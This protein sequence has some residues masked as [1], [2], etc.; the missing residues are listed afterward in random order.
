M[1]LLETTTVLSDEQIGTMLRDHVRAVEGLVQRLED[2][3]FPAKEPLPI[4][5]AVDLG[6]DFAALVERN[7]PADRAAR[8]ALLNVAY[9][10][11]MAILD[12]M[13]M[14]S[15]LPKVPKG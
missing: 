1:P 3:S 13:K 12:I 9:D 5:T 11:L 2:P 8:V 6:R 4:R 7:P 14:H 15:D 10:T